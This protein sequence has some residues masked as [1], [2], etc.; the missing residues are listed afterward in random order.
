MTS[1]LPDIS[2]CWYTGPG[3]GPITLGEKMLFRFMI[4]SIPLI[5]LG[6]GIAHVLGWVR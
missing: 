5:V 6:M 4:G 3:H 1:R 2:G